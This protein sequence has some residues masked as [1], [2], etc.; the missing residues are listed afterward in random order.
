MSDEEK[1]DSARK[2][3]RHRRETDPVFRQRGREADRRSYQRKL[4]D[5][6]SAEELKERHRAAYA[7]RKERRAEQPTVS[8]R[9]SPPGFDRLVG[10]AVRSH[11]RAA[12]LSPTSVAEMLDL[13]RSQFMKYERGETTMTSA[14]LHRLS[15]I[16]GVSIDVFFPGTQPAHPLSA[17]ERS[18]EGRS[19]M[20]VYDGIKDVVVRRRLLALIVRLSEL[21]GR[22]MEDGDI[23]I[24]VD[25]E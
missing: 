12:K 24:S 20:Q 8:R 3:A 1:R 2:Y 13:T 23:A 17:E 25:P 16:L 22:P 15:V 4:Q 21:S 9:G 11:R 7:A 18:A 10:S 14:L 6:A 5:P 19:V